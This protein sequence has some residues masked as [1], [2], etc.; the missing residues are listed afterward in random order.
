MLQQ[1]LLVQ[2]HT[3]VTLALND[4][5]ECNWEDPV[6]K[7]AEQ[8]TN[9]NKPPK[10]LERL[11]Q[12]SETEVSDIVCISD[13]S[14]PVEEGLKVCQERGHNLETKGRE[15]AALFRDTAFDPK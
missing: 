5:M 15:V 11:D 2:L 7:M 4:K 1:H 9:K 13:C 12:E 8:D 6:E 14:L 3:Y 10:L